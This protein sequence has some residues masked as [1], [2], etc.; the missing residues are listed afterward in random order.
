MALLFIAVKAVVLDKLIFH[1]RVKQSG[2]LYMIGEVLAEIP[3]LRRDFLWLV[4][5]VS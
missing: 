4:L 1:G 2:K 5:F 3:F